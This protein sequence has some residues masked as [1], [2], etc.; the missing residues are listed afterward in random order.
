[1]G[2]EQFRRVDLATGAITVLDAGAPQAGV[3][4]Y[5]TK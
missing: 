4:V 1:M 5:Q 2:T 3:F